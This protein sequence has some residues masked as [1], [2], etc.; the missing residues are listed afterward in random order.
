M[1]ELYDKLTPEQI[2]L[3]RRFKKTRIWKL[4]MPATDDIMYLLEQ[5]LLRCRGRDWEDI[6]VDIQITKDGLEAYKYCKKKSN[7]TE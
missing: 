7:L 5:D 1:N 2:D 3:L 4:T 6:L